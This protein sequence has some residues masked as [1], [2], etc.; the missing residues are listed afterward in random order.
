MPL[1]VTI[2][3]VDKAEIMP[4]TWTLMS[5]DVT[6]EVNKIPR[7]R[8]VLFDGNFVKQE[9]PVSNDDFFQPGQEIEISAKEKS[10]VNILLFKGVVTKHTF[11]ADNERSRL[12]VDLKDQA[13]KLTRQRKSAVHEKKDSDIIK[14]IVNTCSGVDP[15]TIEDTNVIHKEIV[16]YNCTDW[17]F[18]LSRADVNGQWVI[19]NDGKLSCIIPK[20]LG[21]V[22]YIF[23]HL[24]NNIY[25]FHMELDGSDQFASTKASGWDI[26]KQKMSEPSE[27]KALEPAL[28]N[29]KA[30]DTADKLGG[31]LCSLIHP[32]PVEPAEAKAW[33]D[34]KAAKNL[35]SMLKG[36]MRVDGEGYGNIEPGN[37]MEII[38]AGDRFTGK[39]FVSGVRHQLTLGGWFADVQFGTH[40]DWFSENDDIIAPPAAGLLPAV[41]G[42]HIGVVDTFKEDPDGHFRVK[43]K[44]PGI[45]S[46]KN[47][48]WA[49][50]AMP[51]AGKK[52]GFFFRPEPEDEVVLG[53][54]ND[55]PRHAVILGSM[56][57]SAK[58]SFSKFKVDKANNI[59]GIKT[60]SGISI[61]IDDKEKK[62]EIKTPGPNTFRLSDKDKRISL[63]DQ[64]MNV[65]KMDDKGI[66]LKSTKQIK[67]SGS[68]VIINGAEIK[69]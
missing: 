44:V 33:A 60:K 3:N 46:D 31:E 25:S 14:K 68:P 66:S 36:S 2:K 69:Q 67:I 22:D 1:E 10:L 28:G 55:D 42:L 63:I 56:Y 49:R 5:V 17:D 26:A 30:K 35:S 7:A 6:K 65:I 45:V 37:S 9:F 51:D 34:A 24:A 53:F 57:S 54:L 43:V 19:V 12:I 27:A 47:S 13:F 8:L 18:I 11:K 52:G 4:G 59:K 23:D 48:I 41:N 50:L 16:Q 64:N 61:I 29:C 32:V 15:G 62:V 38:K 20:I 40:S 39:T 21:E 58:K